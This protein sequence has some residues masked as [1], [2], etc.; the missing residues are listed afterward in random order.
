MKNWLLDQK[1]LFFDG[2][3]GTSSPLNRNW[4]AT[5]ISG[6]GD[7]HLH[8]KKSRHL[9]SSRKLAVIWKNLDSFE[10]IWQIGSHL[11]KSGQF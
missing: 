10:I 4:F 11:E 9:T 2:I 5:Q 1:Y 3:F 7:Y 8:L 6:I